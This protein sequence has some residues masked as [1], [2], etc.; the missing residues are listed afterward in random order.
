MDLHDLHE[1]LLDILLEFDRICRENGIRYSL[2]FGTLL[3]AVRHGGFIPWDDD[4]DVMMDRENYE[5]FC[6][7]CPDALGKDFFFQSR[8]T[9]EKYPYNICRIRKNNTAMIYEAWKNAGIH[10]GIYIDIYPVDHVADNRFARAIQYLF[11]ILNTPVRIARNPEIFASGKK[12]FNGTLKKMVY[13][14]ARIAPPR[15]CERI[16]N[17]FI[18]KYNRRRCKQEG[19]ICEGGTLIHTPRDM[20]PFSSEYLG[21]Y[22]EIEF[23]GHKLMASS[24]AAS[25]LEHW[26]G[27]YMQ[28]PPEEERVVYHQPEVFDTKRSYTEYIG[29]QK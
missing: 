21:D 19:I 14:Y 22:Q 2:A 11:I 9:E 18:Q 6:R 24:H 4:V 26:Y 17:H 29:E 28:L 1:Q 3:G 20:M 13:L 7:I 15:L 25:L 23:E 27:D 12:Q 16:E 8:K 5:K 10:L